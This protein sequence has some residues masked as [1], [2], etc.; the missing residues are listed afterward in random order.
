MKNRSIQKSKK[1][2]N[3]DLISILFQQ[4]E[5]A[6]NLGNYP[7]ALQKYEQVLALDSENLEAK[8]GIINLG[9]ADSSGKLYTKCFRYI[10]ELVKQEP[11][12]PLFLTFLG[13]YHHFQKN[14]ALRKKAREYYEQALDLD[15]LQERAWLGLGYYFTKI[16]I[17]VEKAA[18]CFQCA[19][20]TYIINRGEE[21]GNGVYQLNSTAPLGEIYLE[22]GVCYV[23]LENYD[24]AIDCFKN[25]I[26][27]DR[28]RL[29]AYR[30][31][32]EVYEQK[33]WLKRALQTYQKMLKIT[34]KDLAESEMDWATFPNG[35]KDY[36]TD[37]KF[38]EKRIKKLKKLMKI[39]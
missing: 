2:D 13:F 21:T 19:I 34:L 10:Q 14:K 23:E 6:E 11:D 30:Y 1:V 32:A 33:G 3:S 9:L 24:E 7:D 8:E 28:T 15:P 26:L 29:R 31:L 20:Q 5:A 39:D 27:I 36:S 18:E 12:N 25:S 35:I 37:R 22:L 17:D 38:A 4:A 16:E